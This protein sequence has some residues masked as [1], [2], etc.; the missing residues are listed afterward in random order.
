MDLNLSLTS[1]VLLSGDLKVNRPQIEFM[2]FPHPR[3]QVPSSPPVPESSL[4][5]QPPSTSQGSIVGVSQ[6]LPSLSTDSPLC[7]TPTQPPLHTSHLPAPVDVISYMHPKSI[8][9][10]PSTST[11]TLSK[12]LFSEYLQ[13]PLVGL[14]T[15]LPVSKIS[16]Y[17]KTLI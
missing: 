10:S 7:P 2:V 14:H 4:L 5:T 9:L 8:K 1:L 13:Y 12:P 17:S 3:A 16:G 15:S 11:T 6:I